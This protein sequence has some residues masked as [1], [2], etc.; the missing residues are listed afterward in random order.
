MNK[1]ILLQ[2]LILMLGRTLQQI[3]VKRHMFNVLNL[4]QVHTVAT[5]RIWAM[6]THLC[7][8]FLPF[9]LHVLASFLCKL[10]FEAV[11]TGSLFAVVAEFWVEFRRF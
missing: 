5:H 3:M 4:V 7:S 6:F 1:E 9:F 11:S 10:E 8:L 2:I